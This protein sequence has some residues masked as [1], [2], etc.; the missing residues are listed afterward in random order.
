MGSKELCHQR[1][2]FI[3]DP[4]TGSS[5]VANPLAADILARAKKGIDPAA[6]KA[7]FGSATRWPLLSWKRLGRPAGSTAR[8]QPARLTCQCPAP[9]LAAPDG[10]RHRPQ[11]SREPGVAVIRALR[12]TTDFDL[13]I[14]GLSYDALEPGIYLREMVDKTYQRP[15]PTAGTADLLGRKSEGSPLYSA[16]K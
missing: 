5:F 3:F 7:I 10:G 14:I 13:R 4:A 6:I 1:A 15:C 2:G 16:S 12:E 11:C 8:F 9:P